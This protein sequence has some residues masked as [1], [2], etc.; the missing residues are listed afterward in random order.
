[1]RQPEE[2][3]PLKKYEE[4]C[5]SDR[6]KGDAGKE[7]VEVDLHDCFISKY[8]PQEV[9]DRYEYSDYLIDPNKFRFRTV[10]RI[11][12]L[13]FS[14]LEKIN[15]RRTKRCNTEKTQAFLRRRDFSFCA[16]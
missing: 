5:L 1:M 13:V 16:S 9:G 2:H 14:F 12:A 11:L 15:D 10:I 7:K 6:E 4:I 3:F 8:V